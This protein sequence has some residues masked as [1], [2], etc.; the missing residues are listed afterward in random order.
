[1]RPEDDKR[2]E[3]AMPHPSRHWL[4]PYWRVD[5]TCYIIV[6]C[7]GVDNIEMVCPFLV[8]KVG[9]WFRN[10]ELFEDSWSQSR[11]MAIL[12]EAHTLAY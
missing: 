10:P 3:P 7:S 11:Y 6:G 12:G 4:D 5:G 2:F 1:M 9:C 8:R